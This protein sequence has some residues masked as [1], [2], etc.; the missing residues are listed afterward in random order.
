M[1][2]LLLC[3]FLAIL[4][5]LL[6]IGIFAIEKGDYGYYDL[7][8]NGKVE[9][10][11]TVSLL[12]DVLNEA[13]SGITML[14]VLH[15]LKAVVGS[16]TLAATIT[17]ID[18]AALTATVSTEYFE[19]LTVP[20][21]VFGLNGDL[22]PADFNGVCATI[23]ILSP[24]SAFAEN[25]D[26]TTKGIYAAEANLKFTDIPANDDR[27]ILSMNELNTNVVNGSHANDDI[28][29]ASLVLS[30]RDN[31]VLSS[32]T[33][34]DREKPTRY[35]KSWYPRV[36]KVNDNLYLLLYMY[37]QTGQHLYY[38]TSSD[39]INWDNP[40]VLWDSADY[41]INA[42]NKERHFAMN[43]DACVLDDGTILC[44]FAVRDEKNYRVNPDGC[45]LAMVKG[46]VDES[47]NITWSAPKGIYTG[48]VWEP[49]LLK[50]DDGQIHV[51]FTQVAPDIVEFGYDESHRSSETGLIV[52][53]NNG[54]TWTPDI[55]PGDTN[56]Y[57]ATTV[58][59]EYVGDKDGRP[60]YNG[61]MPVAVQL[62]NGRI[63][64]AVE[65]KD[66]N[67]KFRISTAL[68]GN[69]GEWKPLANGEEGT[70]TK[71]TSSP[72]S[73]PYVDR[74]PSGEVYLTHNYGGK[75]V[76]R[77]GTADVS[78][79]TPTFECAPGCAGI[80]GSC[81]L[82]GSHKMVTA[83]QNKDVYLDENGEA[84][85]K[86][87]N[88]IHLF[89][90]YLNHRINAKKIAV[91]V[92]GYRN[93]WALNTD[94]LFVGAASQAQAALQVAHDKD[95]IHF[96]I[97]RLDHYLSKTGEISS[98]YVA[99]SSN[100]Y[101]R[102]DVADKTKAYTVYFVDANGNE[103]EKS[104][105]ATVYTVTNGN[106]FDT[107]LD[108][109]YLTELS[110]P[111]SALGIEK[112]TSIKAGIGITSVDKGVTT[113]DVSVDLSSTEDWPTVILEK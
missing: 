68:S 50:R 64:M 41:V 29:S 44:V 22:N 63:F 18:T 21:S 11:E 89:Y 27:S 60:H 108:T 33:Q 7:D 77:L 107:N 26:G 35:D 111:K 100:T 37:S 19:N 97:N 109:G 24:A 14:R 36:K 104:S 51:Y 69:G 56:Y 102:I 12:N 55:K 40:L 15:S 16:E 34:A 31:V 39:G 47:N 4:C 32:A 90:H 74:F 66:L 28:D 75:L 73:S 112:S 25:Y 96:L 23:A 94:A 58:Y 86:E 67:G 54:E 70:Y 46:T 83:M 3:T 72:N 49:S 6:S 71:L 80:W 10:S 98:V 62:A 85:E 1:K 57:R 99:A 13:E 5:I 61:Q 95:N 103:T 110:V 9:F 45:G 101:Y 42:E 8:H 81:S 76:A 93:E 30:Y 106:Y 79:F 87:K 105:G 52:S 88:E 82:V 92:D 59:R 17:S 78:T 2:K 53:N 113:T 20:L 91:N 38:V 48:Q 84:T 65:I 43:A